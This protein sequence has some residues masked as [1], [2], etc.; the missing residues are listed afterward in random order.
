MSTQPSEPPEPFDDESER[1]AGPASDQTAA[2]SENSAEPSDAPTAPSGADA[3]SGNAGSDRTGSNEAATARATAR[4]QSAAP[5]P[6]KKP[7][8][9]KTIVK[10]SL[11]VAFISGALEFIFA[12]QVSIGLI[13]FAIAFVA[14]FL[15]FGAMLLVE[16]RI[17]R[18]GEDDESFPRL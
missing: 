3:A 4:A 7:I 12:R 15:G 5:E 17:D 16:R 11:V 1:Q 8:T 6:A 13:A 18:L 14:L 10:M 9:T 2:T